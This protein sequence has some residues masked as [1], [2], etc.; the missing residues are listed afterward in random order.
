MLSFYLW[1]AETMVD[2]QIVEWPS[3]KV[4]LIRDGCLSRRHQHSA[5]V[6][7]FFDAHILF[8]ELGSYFASAA[9]ADFSN[10]FVI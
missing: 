9:A 3:M 8:A 10:L 1:V 7:S 2:W 6:P 5:Q 4:R